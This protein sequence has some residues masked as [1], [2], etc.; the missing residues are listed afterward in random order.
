M[1][2]LVGFDGMNRPVEI[3]SK[4]LL[5][6][7]VVLGRTGSG[8]TGATVTVVEEAVMSGASA[9][10]IDPKGDLTNLALA[11]PG[12]SAGEFAP[13]VEQGKDAAA[14]AAKAK[15]ELGHLA[16]NVA[17]WKSASDVTIYAPGKTQGGG[18]SINLLPSFAPPVGNYT[19]QGFRDRASGVVTSILGAIGRDDD[20]L[21][22]P[23][24]VFLTDVLLAAWK[25][26]ESLSL[27]SWSESLSNPPEDLHEID[28]LS[29][30]EFFPK[31][32]RLKVARAVIGFRRQASKWLE[33]EPLNI[34][35]LVGTS[36]PK[37]SVFTLRHLDEGERQFFCSMLFGAIVGFMF[38]TTA[39]D[40]LKLLVV[41]D[42][43]KGFLPPHPYNPP[44]KKPIC[45]LLAQGRAQGIG[46][47]IGTQNP[48]DMDYKALT[49]VGTWFLGNL[50]ARDCVR[51]L[52]AILEARNIDS[53]S[54][55]T[56]PHR[57]F[58]ILR[59]DAPG[60]ITKTRWAYS[61]L[62]GP[63]NGDE[64]L[65][66]EPVTA[67]SVDSSAPTT[68]DGP[69]TYVVRDFVKVGFTITDVKSGRA[70]VAVLFSTDGGTNWRRATLTSRASV[71]SS[72][73]GEPG[74]VIWDSVADLGH[75]KASVL[76]K[77]EVN[78]RA[79]DQASVFVIDNRSV[80]RRSLLSKLFG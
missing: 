56:V 41:L 59:K 66:L 27:E 57:N 16:S 80:R 15:A 9:I 10:V 25:R 48:N 69:S 75:V 29:L 73:T 5:T 12:L 53:K 1:N 2:M 78:G 72:P 54:V 70:S 65:K 58:L 79:S 76:V 31:K 38:K 35:K 22:D 40:K 30:D 32:E 33:G 55:L 63:L 17:R 67:R 6:H 46:V 23:A 45:T 7:A 11:F 34:D 62:R 24:N 18:R 14:E 4:D 44:T 39:S 52:E 3:P 20:P 60:V 49:N 19:A 50:R 68:A 43:A 28:G 13:W 36:K 47:V 74:S 21:T 26:G 71:P 61:Y 77:I 8:K 42:E 37:V 64:L 51:D